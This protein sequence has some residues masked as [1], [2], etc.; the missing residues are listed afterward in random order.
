MSKEK[1]IANKGWSN[2][3]VMTLIMDGATTYYPTGET[4]RSQILAEKKL[5]Y[6][7]GSYKINGRDRLL[8]WPSRSLEVAIYPD[9]DRFFVPGSLNQAKCK[10]KMLIETD[11]TKLRKRLGMEN[12]DIIFPEASEAI[13]VFFQ[14]YEAVGMRL[15]GRDYNFLWMRTATFTNNVHPRRFAR[16]GAWADAG[17]LYIRDWF[18]NRGLPDLG[19]ARWIV[20]RRR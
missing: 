6:Q 19:V 15:L 9:P 5:C 16:V 12:I 11:V 10:Q 2:E 17:T 4:V 3:E 13:E 1:L 8:D 18:A 14:H 20:P 7:L